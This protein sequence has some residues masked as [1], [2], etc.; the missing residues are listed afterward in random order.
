MIFAFS[1]ATARHI[2]DR[3][4]PIVV[5]PANGYSDLRLHRPTE[6]LE[7]DHELDDVDHDNRDWNRFPF[8][9]ALHTT[10]LSWLLRDTK[11]VQAVLSESAAVLLGPEEG[12]LVSDRI[13]GITPH[14]TTISAWQVRMDLLTLLY[15][16][17]ELK[18][19]MINIRHLG[20][21]MSPIKGWHWL[22]CREETITHSPEQVEAGNLKPI[23]WSSKRLT[24]SLVGLGESTATSVGAHVVRSIIHRSGTY[25]DKYRSEVKSWLS[26][27][28]KERL[29]NDLPVTAIHAMSAHAKMSACT[30]D[31]QFLFPDSLPN[32][33]PLAYILQLAQGRD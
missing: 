1:E 5:L 29:V 17:E 32:L 13:K 25:V 21:D 16:R 14:Q 4:C 3:S 31:R 24:P 23:H 22:C 30:D 28:S 11:N 19:D 6:L 20:G 10:K 15:Q 7:S 12:Y 33:G 8:T 27:Q 26:D 9:V 18:S 2:A